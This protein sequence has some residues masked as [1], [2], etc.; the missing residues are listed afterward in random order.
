[1]NEIEQF[2]FDW[3]YTSIAFFSSVGFILAV[4]RIATLMFAAYLKSVSEA[5]E[6][7]LI[8][9]RQDNQGDVISEFIKIIKNQQ[10]DIK[11]YCKA[12]EDDAIASTICKQLLER[13]NITIKE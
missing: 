8:N 12:K 10:D 1:M 13:N 6:K 5:V 2:F 7:A 4:G 3:K 11:R 9:Q